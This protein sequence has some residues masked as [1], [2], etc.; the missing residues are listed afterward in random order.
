MYLAHNG[1]RV[2]VNPGT[3]GY[4]FN[5]NLRTNPHD[6]TVESKAKCSYTYRNAKLTI[7]GRAPKPFDGSFGTGAQNIIQTAYLARVGG[8]ERSNCIGTRETSIPIQ[9]SVSLEYENMYKPE[10]KMQGSKKG[11]CTIQ[12]TSIHIAVPPRRQQDKGYRW[13]DAQ[14]KNHLENGGP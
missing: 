2:D 13:T 5:L 1:I 4:E 6:Q 14:I 11:N 12:G 8:V 9:F 7:T 3:I 10:E